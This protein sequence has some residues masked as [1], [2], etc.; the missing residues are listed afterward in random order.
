MLSAF[1]VASGMLLVSVE[2]VNEVQAVPWAAEGDLGLAAVAQRRDDIASWC[3]SNCA[4]TAGS[5]PLV[6]AVYSRLHA[7]LS[8]GR[9]K[10]EGDR[11]VGE[12]CPC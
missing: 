7:V 9:F 3:R 10:I 12:R 11:P 6:Q 1:L 4:A 2:G 8:V 5:A